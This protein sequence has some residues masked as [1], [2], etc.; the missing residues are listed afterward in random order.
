MLLGEFIDTR[1]LR[2][3]RTRYG[4]LGGLVRGVE[5]NGAFG[6]AGV[7]NRFRCIGRSGAGY[8]RFGVVGWEMVGEGIPG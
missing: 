6:R 1:R 8:G 3:G 5:I 4:R 7:A 2:R